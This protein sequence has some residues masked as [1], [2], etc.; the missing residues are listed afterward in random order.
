LGLI[1]GEGYTYE[2]WVGL[3]KGLL[4]YGICDV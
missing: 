2:A 3:F 4:V 1:T